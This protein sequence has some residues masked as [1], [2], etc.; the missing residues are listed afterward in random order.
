MKPFKLAIS[1]LVFPL[2]AFAQTDSGYE[3]SMGELVRR[4]AI[5]RNESGPVI[6]EIAYYKDNESPGE[7]QVLWN[8]ENDAAYCDARL[9]EFSEKLEGWGWTCVARNEDATD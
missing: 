9:A 5:E 7:R 1:I 3:C 4:V 2:I 6:C 8:A